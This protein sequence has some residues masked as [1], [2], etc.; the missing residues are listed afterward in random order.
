MIGV[1]VAMKKM[2]VI[3]IIPIVNKRSY[4]MEEVFGIIV[5]SYDCGSWITT[6][7]STPIV[8]TTKLKAQEYIDNNLTGLYN[9]YNVISIKIV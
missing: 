7:I 8:F 5:G 3:C 2:N 1:L 4:L 6:M 9:R